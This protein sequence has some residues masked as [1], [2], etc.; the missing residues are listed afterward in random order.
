MFDFYE[1]PVIRVNQE[2]YAEGLP[3]YAAILTK[4]LVELKDETGKILPFEA[5]PL[6]LDEASDDRVTVANLGRL[7][8]G[9]Y[10]LE[11]PEGNRTLTVSARPWNAVTGALIKGLYYQRC[12][13]ELKPMT[14]VTMANM[15]APEP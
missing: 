3:V 8:A 14:R 4:G 5:E 10:I 12:G 6:K 2:G 15:W 13:C 1:G 9:T 11:S 7:K